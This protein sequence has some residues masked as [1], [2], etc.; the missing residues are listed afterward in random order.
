M[1][2]C[3]KALQ[4]VLEEEENECG[5][6]VSGKWKWGEDNFL[7]VIGKRSP[8]SAVGFGYFLIISTFPII[9]KHFVDQST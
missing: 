8:G 4:V 9:T 6:G 1:W 7:L 2:K 5:S 3:F